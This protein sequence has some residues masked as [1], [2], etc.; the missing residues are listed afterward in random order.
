M[1][2]LTTTGRMTALVGIALLLAISTTVLA[3]TG[4]G[5]DLSWGTVDGGGGIVSG[6]GYTLIG[7]TG[8]PDASASLS[9][10]GYTLT[11]GF[12]PG[13]ISGSTV[14]NVYLPLMIWS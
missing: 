8:Q 4:G 11:G 10:G 1:K 13:A 3:Q 9:G 2:H 7:T 6:S 12:W 14:R 5:Y